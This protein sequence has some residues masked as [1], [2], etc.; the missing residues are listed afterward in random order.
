MVTMVAPNIESAYIRDQDPRQYQVPAEDKGHH[1]RE[2]SRVD[3]ARYYAAAPIDADGEAETGRG[4]R[5]IVE[6]KF[7]SK[8]VV[9]R[10]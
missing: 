2:A 10:L 4:F 1:P 7:P 8:S 5:G 6:E 9:A 3:F